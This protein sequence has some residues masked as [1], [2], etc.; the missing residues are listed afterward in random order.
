MRLSGKA[1]RALLSA[2]LIALGAGSA[3]A[4][5]GEQLLNE[6]CVACHEQKADGGLAR[7]ADIRK[8]PEGWDMNIVRM[9]IV[10][11][12]EVN[13]EERA[14]LVKHLADTRGLAPSETAGYRYILERTPDAIDNVP[15]E[16]LGAMCGRCHSFARVAL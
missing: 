9:M 7:I 4:Q 5:S 16:D 8:T 2:G 12:V 11:G 1:T 14:A 3:L 15:S 13:P 10:H 6:R